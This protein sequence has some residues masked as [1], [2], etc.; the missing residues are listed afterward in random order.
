MFILWWVLFPGNVLV[1]EV[2]LSL[3]LWGFLHTSLLDP[4]ITLLSNLSPRGLSSCFGALL[5]CQATGRKLST[6]VG[7]KIVGGERSND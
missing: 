6:G 2:S 1:L 7:R 4:L 3:V 5:L